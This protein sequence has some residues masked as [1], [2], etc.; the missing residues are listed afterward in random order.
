MDTVTGARQRLLTSDDYR[1]HCFFPVI[2]R[3]V[4]ELQQRFPSE[5]SDILKGATALNPKHTT[6]MDNDCLWP[7]AK[8]YGIIKEKLFAEIHQGK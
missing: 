4:S 8:H 5:S 1:E 2:D 6:F 3:L 7:M